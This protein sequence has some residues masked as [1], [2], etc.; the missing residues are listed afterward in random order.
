MK[1]VLMTK[2]FARWCGLPDKVLCEAARQI[3]SG[4]EKASDAKVE[5]ALREGTFKEICN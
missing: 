5:E 2:A 1:R 3:A 4:L